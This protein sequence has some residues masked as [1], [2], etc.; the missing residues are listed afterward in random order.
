MS[1]EAEEGFGSADMKFVESMMSCCT[2][3]FAHRKAVGLNSVPALVP[4][5]E[6]E[7]ASLIQYTPSTSI[8]SLV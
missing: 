3:F 2:V 1:G 7:H 5:L 8:S 4:A 6:L